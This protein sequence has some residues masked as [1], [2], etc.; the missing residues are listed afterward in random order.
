MVGW[1]ASQRMRWWGGKEGGFVTA[2][3]VVAEGAV[4]EFDDVPSS[5][6]GA[7]V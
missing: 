6:P 3:R 7:L 1:D 5:D 2:V 4:G